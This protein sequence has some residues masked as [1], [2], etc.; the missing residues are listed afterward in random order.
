MKRYLLVLIVLLNFLSASVF[1]DTFVVR[2]IEVEGLQRISPDT[3]ISY[4][5]IKQGQ[6]FHSDSS[7]KI[8]EALY[9]TGF[10]DHISIARSGSTLIVNVVERPIIGQLKIKGNSAIPTDKLTT[11]MKSVNIAEGRVYDRAM[12]DRIK[13]SLLAQ[14]YELGRYNARVDVTV[15]P[16]TRNRVKVNIDISEGLVAKVRH[17]NVIGN[18][19]FSAATLDKHLDLST[20]GLVA[21]FTQTDRYSED[22]LQ[23]SM[24]KLHNYYLDHGYLKMAVK[25]SQAEVTPDRKSVYLTIVIEEGDVYTVSGVTLTGDTIIPH[26]EMFNMIKIKKGDTFSRQAIMDAEKSMSD[27]LGDRGYISA[28][29]NVTPKIDEVHKTVFLN[30]TVKP[31]KRVYVRHIN[32]IDNSKTND[33]A[34]RRDITQMESAVISSKKLDDSK[35]RLKLEPY[36]KDVDMNVVPVPGHDDLADVDYKVTEQNAAEATFSVGYSQ[37]DR[38]ILGAGFNQKNFLGTGNTLGVNAS[39]SRFQQYYGISYTDPY[40]TQDGI[41][42]TVSLSLSKFNPSAANI[43]SSYSTDEYDADVIYGI[44]I[45]QEDGV[46]NTVQLGYGLQDTMVN[47]NNYLPSVSQQ[48]LAFDND[49]GHH[50]QQIDLISGYSRDSRDRAIFPTRG[51][52]Q[53]LGFN[54]YVPAGAGSLKYYTAAYDGKWY[55]PIV[56]S[57]I[58]EAKGDVA[59]GSAFSGVKSYPFFKNYYA[60]GFDSVQ[61]YLGN[62]LGPQDSTTSPSGGNLLADASVGIIFPNPM[63]D[64]LRTSVFIDGGNV[65]ETFDNRQYGGTAGGPP[66]LSYGVEADWLTPLGMMIDLSLAEPIN[67][68]PHDKR[69][70][71]QFSL[72][73]NF[74]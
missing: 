39:H 30:F 56:G 17:I 8:I 65:Y 23:S 32:F 41:S 66:R 45:G 31:N 71:F 10:F 63:D 68:E 15:T 38:L 13:Q 73:A 51:A 25:S 40:Y 2:N 27:A 12:L 69:E 62:S 37:I 70:A 33:V 53:S 44:P 50:F 36:I 43:T 74:G 48:V 24:E 16:D 54:I 58:A 4:L 26:D 52:L 20:P 46:F 49:F 60:G 11:V 72:G 7:A 18:H 61:G 14:Y 3:V 5:P 19:A 35:H 67:A 22:K 28:L 57:F 21:F 42:R 64:T 1:A 34:L 47:L 9:K 59:F 29:F 6:T 55:H